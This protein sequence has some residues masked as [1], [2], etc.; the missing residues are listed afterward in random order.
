MEGSGSSNSQVICNMMVIVG[1]S[2]EDEPGGNL[3]A[4]S[5]KDWHLA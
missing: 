2:E 5:Q 1:E 4:V 3:L